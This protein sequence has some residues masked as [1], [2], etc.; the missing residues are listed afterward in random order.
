[1]L[2][3]AGNAAQDIVGLQF[4]VKRADPALEFGE[5]FHLREDDIGICARTTL[6]SMATSMAISAWSSVKSTWLRW[7]ARASRAAWRRPSTS[8][9]TNGPLWGWLPLALRAMKRAMTAW[10]ALSTA[11]GSTQRCSRARESRVRRSG[12][13]RSRVGEAQ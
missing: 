4:G 3:D 8:A 10:R 6:A 7:M 2:A 1:M 13:T 11:S 5:R 9:S 12:R